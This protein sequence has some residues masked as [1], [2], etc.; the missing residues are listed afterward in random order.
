MLFSQFVDVQRKDF[1]EMFIHHLTTIFLIIFSYSC[2]LIRGGSLVLIVH[3]IADIF[4][5]A[6]K[7]CKYVK[8]QRSCDICFG[9]FFAVW[10]ATRLVIF[11]G[12]L[13]RK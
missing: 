5:E 7:I 4:M 11:P 1:L 9:L 3:D 8:W 6:A 2:N 13:I 10:T 12:Y